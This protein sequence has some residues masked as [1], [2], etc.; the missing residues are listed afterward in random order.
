[1][2]E[3][4]ENQRVV[5]TGT[6]TTRLTPT[7]R[8]AFGVL[9]G[10]AAQLRGAALPTE[11]KRR[12]HRKRKRKK[13]VTLCQDDQTITV[14]KKQQQGYLD[15]G[16]TVGACTCLPPTQNLQAAID[17]AA[18][19]T[20][21]EL[22]PGTWQ[23][24][25]FPNPFDAAMTLAKNLRIVGAGS[26]RTV[27]TGKGANI[28][29]M[30]VERQAVVHVEGLTLTEFVPAYKSGAGI[31]NDG[32]LTLVDVVISRCG[33]TDN[34]NSGGG[35]YNTG[36]LS[37]NNC[38]VTQNAS[39]TR[40]GIANLGTATLSNCR[41]TNNHTGSPGQ[42]CCGGIGNS[43][44]MTLIDTLVA[45]NKESNGQGGGIGNSGMLTLDRSHVTRNTAMNRCGPEPMAGGIFNG[46]GGSVVLKNG[47]TITNNSPSNC[48]GSDPPIPGCID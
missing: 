5:N 24:P 25:G 44:T 37:L 42:T 35:I 47:S 34:N 2:N 30:I 3:S 45:E 31:F 7:R 9:L 20:T 27:V 14:K 28:H 10:L 29:G 33:I 6:A 40:G 21:I 1:M 4:A 22:C 41:I 26:E 39:D 23:F 17:A 48:V 12:K 36:T 8:G 15:D 16:A 13:K 11:A 46:T 32:S 38:S 18:P 43:G 19:G